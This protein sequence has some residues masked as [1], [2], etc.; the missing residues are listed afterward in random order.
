MT[1]GLVFVLP[2]FAGGGAE[3]VMLHLLGGIDRSHF[4]PTLIVLR[5]DGPLADLLPGD[6]PLVDLAR[7][8]L[9]QHTPGNREM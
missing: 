1:H 8:R 9:R 5:G 6:V 7:P 4:L 2:S 3:R